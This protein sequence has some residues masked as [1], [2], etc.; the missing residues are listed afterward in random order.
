MQIESIAIESIQPFAGNAKTHPVEQIKKLAKEITEVGFTQPIVI[1]ASDTIVAG[2]GRYQAALLLKLETVPCVRLSS[3]LSEERIRAIRLFDNKIAET[4]WDAD[5][6]IEELEWFTE[7]N[8][9]LDDTGF[10]LDDFNQLIKPDDNKSIDAVDPN[11]IDEFCMFVTCETE[12]HLQQLFE[13]LRE[14]G[15]QVKLT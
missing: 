5:L 1:D 7:Q 11:V 15:Y 13:E 2:H 6:L 4:K 3:E 12:E 9:T 8:L 14:R 10:S